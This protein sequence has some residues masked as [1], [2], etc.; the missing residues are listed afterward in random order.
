MAQNIIL[1]I[2]LREYDSALSILTRMKTA[3]LTE[4]AEGT[5]SVAAE[6]GSLVD[7]LTRACKDLEEALGKQHE[8]ILENMRIVRAIVDRAEKVV[9]DDAWPLPKYREMLFI[10]N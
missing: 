9:S 2:I 1:P 7:V 5:R 10:Y 6:L 4:G 3:G 8:D